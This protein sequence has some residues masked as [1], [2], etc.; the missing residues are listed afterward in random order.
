MET[1]GRAALSVLDMAGESALKGPR[2]WSMQRGKK[3]G[4][5]FRQWLL[6]AFVLVIAPLGLAALQA[7]LTL[8]RTAR[9]SRDTAD[10]AVHQTQAV[11][12]LAERTVAMER[13]ARQYL[14]LDDSRLR[15][16]F[17]AAW[18]EA[19]STQAQLMSVLPAAA[20]Q[21]LN[22]W[23][24]QAALAASFLKPGGQRQAGAQL[25]TPVFAR[26]HALNESLA[27]RSRLDLQRRNDSLQDSLGAQRRIISGLVFGA[28]LLALLLA[29]GL[30][31][32]LS[33]P[34][35]HIEASI[36]RLG[37]KQFDQP[38]QV[39]GPADLRRLGQQLDWLRQRL[40][41]L[42]SDKTRFIRHI[43]HELNT[44]LA[45]IREGVALLQDGVA[46]SLSTDQTEV[47]RILRDNTAALQ[48]QIEDL[49]RF[50]A[51]ASEFQQLRRQPVDLLELL[52]QVVQAQR[53]RWQAKSL[54]L[55][56]GGSAGT[57]PVDGEKLAM[58]LGNLLSNAVR[59]SPPGGRIRFTVS[60]QA[61]GWCID[62]IDQGPGVA[63][64]DGERIFDPFYQGR[65]QVP[66]PRQGSGIGLSIVRE[67]V[68]AHG[69]RVQLLPSSVGAHFRIELPGVADV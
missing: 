56:V 35:A 25:L 43:S 52:Q 47:V 62:C 12:R 60:K 54:Q 9:Q 40:A 42:E 8:E 17:E 16:R 44:P 4:L 33:R 45:S 1:A 65:N 21:D 38:V 53:L 32:W 6:A 67:T 61:E 2:A 34:M 59:F 49:L 28:L 3:R 27:E 57:A 58:A 41:T 68:L 14:V 69:G 19:R 46:G 23:A 13:S 37:K 51:L 11:Q 55:D 15:D 18:L 10:H 26:L 7:L 50:H 39:R 48:G 63:D 64:D 29:F 20:Q 36:E 30:G 31:A 66:G 22:E 5:S 24:T